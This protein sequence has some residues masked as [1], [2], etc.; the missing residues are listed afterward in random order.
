MHQD[1][2]DLAVIPTHDASLV[3]SVVISRVRTVVAIDEPKMKA[4]TDPQ[5]RQARSFMD[6]T[7][8]GNPSLVH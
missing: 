2:S 3:T 1:E 7:P 6:V 5:P 8:N 4:A